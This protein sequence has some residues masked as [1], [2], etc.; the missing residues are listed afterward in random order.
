[1]LFQSLLVILLAFP[2]FYGDNEAPADRRAR[3][4][5]M[6]KAIGRAVHGANCHEDDEALVGIARRATRPSLA[7]YDYWLCIAVL[8]RDM[9]EDEA[10]EFFEFNTMGAWVGEGTPIVLDLSDPLVVP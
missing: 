9:P 10:I 3:M 7:A 4:V 6:A 2:S 5:I 1:M 8:V